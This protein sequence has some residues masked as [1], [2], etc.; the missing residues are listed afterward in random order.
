MEKEMVREE[1]VKNKVKFN[2]SSIKIKLL[3][4]PI[5]LVIISIVTISMI[6]NY[7]SKNSLLDQMNK[8]G[9]FVLREVVGRIEDN[10]KSLEVINNSLEND[11]I[12]A[13]KSMRRLGDGVS[14]EKMTQ[15]AEDLG[16]NQLNFWDENG[17][18]IYSNIPENIGY[19]P[20]GEK[21]HPMSKFINSDE[22]ELME[23]IR[24]DTVS[25]V[26]IK[27]GAIKN[28]DGTL[29]QAGINA[30]HINELTEQFS[31]QR[32]MEELVLDEEI[33][34]TTFIDKNLVAIADS[35]PEDI[36]TDFSKDEAI[37]SAV[38]E[39]VPYSSEYEFGKDKIKV[40]DIVYPVVIDGENIGAINMGLSM[41]AVNSSIFKNLYTIAFAGLITISLLGFILFSTSN[42]AVKT[43]NKLKQ[44]MNYMALGDFREDVPVD[45]MEKQDEFGEIA[46]SVNT[47]QQ[48]IRE[49]IKNV[50][51]KSHM[52]AAHSE[53]LTATTHESEKASDEVSKVIQEIA[54]GAS[55][56]AIDTEQG[57]AT[58]EELGDVVLKNTKHIKTLNESTKKVNYLKDEG[59]EL[60]KDLVEKTN[61]NIKSS[62]E[63][64]EVIKDTNLS[65]EKIVIASEMI[66]SIADQTNLLALNA[67]IE[68]A[69]AGE[70]G[71]GFAVVADEIRKLAEESN[72]FTE[73]IG[74]IIK[75]LKA[76]TSS[77]VQTM[78][79]VGEVVKS[80][81][82]SVELTSSKFDGI[83]HALD[84]MEHAIDEVNSSSDEMINQK[85]KIKEVMEHLVAISE[86]NAAG[87]QE[88]SASVEE[89]N[90]AMTE[91]SGASDELS[92]IA[93]ELNFM[94]GKFKV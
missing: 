4:I 14:N 63:V 11:I 76:K 87:A 42:Y 24:H 9:E 45:I 91:I 60:I 54:V 58:A 2:K 72:R 23:G 41:E 56:Q 32:L 78:E 25:D 44:L 92:R 47:M 7:M 94:I 67:A 21:D 43:I 6:S 90:A 15:L 77:A 10:S 65:T 89:Q 64:Q 8:N 79:E 33:V 57:V 50:L 34:Y 1:K 81:E 59:L 86:E 74:V 66:K 12:Q 48:A 83:A 13:T 40:Y 69:R 22:T 62:I 17:V 80:Q 39:G 16:A 35:N 3:I 61:I 55:E 88:A 20:A 49:M 26:Y 18:I 70:A 30:D 53:E 28:T 29:L 38:T 82:T 37:I 52:V 85:E 75:E 31:Y 71:R 51:D 93:E 27:Y 68:A 5:I 36:G 84:E 19:D 46:K 73:E